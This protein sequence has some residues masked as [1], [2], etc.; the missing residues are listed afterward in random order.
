MLVSTYEFAKSYYWRYVD[1]H[2]NKYELEF[3]Q[4]RTVQDS[5]CK[6]FLS[7]YRHLL[8]NPESD[9]ENL[10]S[11]LSHIE[12]QDLRTF[13]KFF[14]IRMRMIREDAGGEMVCLRDYQ[15]LEGYIRGDE[16]L[17]NFFVVSLYYYF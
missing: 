3:L 17:F 4:A 14:A 6:R 1:M 15:D 2:L 9:I 8:A 13:L 10:C 7:R 5:A 16:E 12:E 11:V